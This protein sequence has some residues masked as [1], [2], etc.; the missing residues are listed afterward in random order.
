[1]FKINTNIQ[2]VHE[3]ELFIFHFF[4]FDKFLRLI[5]I[6]FILDETINNENSFLIK[7][8]S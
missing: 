1:M 7:K 3:V 5:S 4:G 6:N 2:C 8:T